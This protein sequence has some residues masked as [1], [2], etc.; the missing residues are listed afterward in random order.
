MNARSHI[1]LLPVFLTCACQSAGIEHRVSSHLLQGL[2]ASGDLNRA[3]RDLEE[4]QT[5][6]KS[7][8]QELKLAQLQLYKTE[9]SLELNEERLDRERDLLKAATEY[10]SEKDAQVSTERL[11]ALGALLKAN[12]KEIAWHEADVDYAQVNLD[13]ADARVVLAEAQLH[14]ARA[15]AVQQSDKP[16]K[17]Q[18]SMVD[19]KKQVASALEEVSDLEQRSGAAWEK[20]K[21]QRAAYEAALT[22]VPPTLSSDQQLLVKAQDENRILTGNL[23]AMKERLLKLEQ[24]NEALKVAAQKQP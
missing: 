1:L 21:T 14:S 18:L 3:Q 2:P 5:A 23:D 7:A 9:T 24:E 12:E 22:L 6:Q 16:A 17:T 13:L 19:F 10:Q 8:A 15:L 11:E 20:V 4:S